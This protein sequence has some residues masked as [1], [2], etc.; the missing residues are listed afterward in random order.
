MKPEP[1]QPLPEDF[2]VNDL[3]NIVY[4]FITFESRQRE[5]KLKLPRLEAKM[6]EVMSIQKLDRKKVE[7]KPLP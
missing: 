1:K 5:Q 2:S 4:D 6:D 7:E 3:E